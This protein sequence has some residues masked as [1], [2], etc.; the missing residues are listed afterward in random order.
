MVKIMKII[1]IGF[2]SCGKSATGE[3]LARKLKLEFIDL[4]TTI[5]EVHEKEKGQKLSCREIMRTY[6]QDE[7]REYEFKALKTINSVDNIV[8]STGGGAPIPLKSREII[9]DLGT[10]VYLNPEPSIIMNRMASKGFPAY[11]GENPTLNDLVNVWKE[12][13][14]VYESIADII[15]NNSVMSVDD[16]VNRICDRMDIKI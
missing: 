13:H 3:A 8:L 2:T 14:V 1:L 10:I 15:I 5:I 12:R 16:T 4:D 9:K 7:F 11:L 6:G